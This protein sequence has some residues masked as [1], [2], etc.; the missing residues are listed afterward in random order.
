MSWRWILAAL[1]MALA[2]MTAPAAVAAGG[3]PPASAGWHGRAIRQ[4]LPRV[5]GDAAAR[6]PRGWSAGGVG[7]GSGYRSANGSRRVR[8]VQRRLV[9]RGYRPGPVDGRYGPRTR[10]A[11]VWFEIKHGL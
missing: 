3:E 1:A 5:V 6:F 7:R 4:P 10:A 8:E 2:W 9:R 11:V